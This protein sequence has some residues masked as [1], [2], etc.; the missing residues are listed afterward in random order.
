MGLFLLLRN[1]DL[2]R[3]PRSSA[4]PSLEQLVSSGTRW[5]EPEQEVL[6][7]PGRSGWQEGGCMGASWVGP[8][9]GG[10][11][12][13]GGLHYQ[14]VMW[15]VK[16]VMLRGMGRDQVRGDTAERDHWRDI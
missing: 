6:S 10:L 8:G 2:A 16:W 11:D 9:R 1:A 14:E 13:E 7:G 12:L 4:S 3:S 15:P 5:S